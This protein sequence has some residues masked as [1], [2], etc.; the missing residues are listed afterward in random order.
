MKNKQQFVDVISELGKI[1]KKEASATLALVLAAI[2]KACKEDGG[3][4]LAGVGKVEVKNTKASSGTMNG[5]AWSKPA[6]QTVKVKLA[7]NFIEEI[8]GE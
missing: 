1:S 2:Q 3:V 8:V 4:N 6:G 5:V 7:K